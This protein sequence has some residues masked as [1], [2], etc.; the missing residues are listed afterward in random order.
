MIIQ[1]LRPDQI[2]LIKLIETGNARLHFSQL[3]EDAVLWHLFSAKFGGFYVDVGCHHPYRYSNTALLSEINAW[4]GINI[5]LDERAIAAFRAARPNDLNLQLAIGKE[6]GEHAVTMF[7]DGAVNSLDENMAKNQSNIR[8]VESVKL[9]QVRPLSSVLDEYLPIGTS[10]DFMNVDAEGWD[11]LVL[12]SNNWEKYRPNVIAVESHGFNLNRP[13]DNKT[14]Q[15]LRE[16]KYSLVSH[17]VV[18]SIYKSEI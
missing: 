14:F 13:G 9:I 11:H 12:E 6:I 3:G 10:I 2:H 7:K 15:F 4:K 5:D 16:R 8:E 17:C 1:N 18:T